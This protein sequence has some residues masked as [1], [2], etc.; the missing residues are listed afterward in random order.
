MTGNLSV[1]ETATLFHAS[2]P[3]LF[4][5]SAELVMKL[6]SASSTAEEFISI[7]GRKTSMAWR[8]KSLDQDGTNIKF[9]RNLAL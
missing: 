9:R 8:I 2:L 5:I 4:D 3:M 6:L 1:E 7:R